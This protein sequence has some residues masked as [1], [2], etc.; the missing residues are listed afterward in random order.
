MNIKVKNITLL[1]NP[2]RS[3]CCK[4]RFYT[5]VYKAQTELNKFATKKIDNP[6]KPGKKITVKELI[7]KIQVDGY[8]WSPVTGKLDILHGSGGVKNEPFTNLI[9]NTKD[10]NQLERFK[11]V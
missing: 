8:K 4:N 3:E 9:F 11:G 10:I 7:K 5:E 2:K 6:F 1:A